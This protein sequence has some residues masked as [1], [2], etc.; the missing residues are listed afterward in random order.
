MMWRPMMKKALSI[1]RYFYKYIYNTSKGYFVVL[2]INIIFVA[3]SPINSMLLTKSLL[4]SIIEK[5]NII[6]WLILLVVSNFIIGVVINFTKEIR[7]KYEDRFSREFDLDLSKKNMETK[8]SDT[9]KASNIEA[10]NKAVTGMSW[11]SGGVRG[12]SDCFVGII[13]SILTLIGVTY[14]I[15]TISVSLII[16]AVITVSVNT[17]STSKCNK[18]QQ[19]VFSI[20]PAINKFYHYIYQKVTDRKYAKEIRLYN[21]SNMILNKELENAKE[22][23]KIDNRCACK[24]TFWGCLGGVTS[25]LNYCVVYVYLGLLAL[26]GR[27]SI[28]EVVLC[29][30]AVDA[31]VNG[32][33]ISIIR[34][35]QDIGLKCDFMG[36]FIDFM[37]SDEKIKSGN[38]IVDEFQFEQLDFKNVYF[39]YPGNNDYILENVSFTIRKNESVSFVGLNGAGK[40]T[41]VKLLCR[42]YTVTDGEILLNGVSIYDY[43]YK[44]YLKHLS[45]VFQDFKLLGYS[46][47]ENIKMGDRDK[48]FK[49]SDI[50]NRSG[51]NSW[52]EKQKYKGNTLLYRDYDSEGVEPS[53]GIAQKIAIARALQRDSSIIILDEPTAAL[54]PVA[55]YEIYER[56]NQLVKNKTAIY[57]SHRLSSCKF[58]DRIIVINKKSVAEEGNHYELLKKGGLYAEM[59]NTQASWYKKAELA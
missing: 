16:C 49:R 2:F 48:P 30:S 31:L 21:A 12:L 5:E 4:D 52:V 39:K 22:L 19:E 58:C 20:T 33:L 13:S 59:Y 36:A 7:L 32:C 1:C 6:S 38:L 53:G 50:Y 8:Y 29:V 9:E 11:Y 45:V 47:D 35:V 27:I 26:Q 34:L 56:F 43:E 15:S 55:E 18:A 14:I 28:S 25:A 51:L 57:I 37:K 24:Q 42:L 46:I 40:S 17:L 41:I 54:D 23:N 44:E 10:L 3:I